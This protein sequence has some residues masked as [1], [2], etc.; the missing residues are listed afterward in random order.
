MS[1]PQPSFVPALNA[2]IQRAMVDVSAIANLHRLSG[3]ASQ[4]TW[5][6]DAL[7]GDSIRPLVLR[8]AP[9]GALVPRSATAVSLAT[10]ARVIRLAE[11]ARVPVPPVPYVLQDSDELGPGYIMGRIEGETIA[12]GIL[13]IPRVGRAEDIADAIASIAGPDGRW[14]T[15]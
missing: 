1:A 11:A 12:R 5:S 4:E 7:T 2:A 6:F 10:E 15:G 13:A 14:I 8:R 3:G 9:G